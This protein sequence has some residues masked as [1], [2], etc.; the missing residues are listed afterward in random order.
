MMTNRQI[1]IRT[2]LNLYAQIPGAP[3]LAR[4]CDRALANLF[5]DRQIPIDIVETA[6]LLGAAR[7][8]FHRH[9]PAPPIR[10]LDY[11]EPIVEELLAEPPR[12]DSFDVMDFTPN[13]EP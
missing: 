7:R 8:M 11:F 4:P 5:F 1:Y 2:V 3:L 6:L 12:P 13:P 10:S 9:W